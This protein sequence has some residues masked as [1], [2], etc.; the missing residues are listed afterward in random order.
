[1][2]PRELEVLNIICAAGGKSLTSTDIVNCKRDLT[3]S[4]VIA[5][6]RRLNAIGAVEVAGATH[7]GKVLSRTYIPGPKAKEIIREYYT[8]ELTRTKGILSAD[9]IKEIVEEVYGQEKR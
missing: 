4:T 3:Q 7:S 5:V 8:E 2:N 1:M 6:L 9:D